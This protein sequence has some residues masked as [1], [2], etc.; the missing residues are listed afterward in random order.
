MH[1]AMLR[2]LREVSDFLEFA[3]FINLVLTNTLGPH[4]PSNR[5]TWQS[6][7]RKHHNQITNI[8]VRSVSDQ[9][10]TFIGPEAF[11]EQI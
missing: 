9:E 5:W 10:L 6:S 3:T 2:Q 1:L 7:D 4:K 8:L 11:L